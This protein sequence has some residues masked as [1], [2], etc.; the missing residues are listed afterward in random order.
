[1]KIIVFSSLAY[2]LV[3]FRGRLLRAMVA[4]GHDV[5][6]CAPDDNSDVRA[7]LSD[8]G[9]E[10][11][12][13]PMARTGLNPLEDIKTLRKMVAL[14]RDERPD[15]V[16]AYT[17][18][19][20]IYGGVAAR[21]V[22]GIR[23]YAMCSGLGHVYSGGGLRIGILRR[24]VSGLYR[25][26][27]SK[28]DGVFVFNRDDAQEMR[29]HRIVSPHQIVTRVNGSGIDVARFAW[30]P[31]SSGPPVFLM[32]AR[33][34]RD[35]GPADFAKA[36][37]MVKAVNKDAKFRLLGPFDANPNSVTQKELD[38]WQEES[39]IEYL[40]STTDVRP[41]LTRCT[42]FVLPTF[43]R[44]GLPRTILEAMATGRAIITTDTPG[45]RE[46]VIE[47]ENG[48]LVKPRDPEGL[49]RA[50]IQIASVEGRA[51]DFG[52]VS[53]KI[54][55]DRFAVEKVNA[56]LLSLM[57]LD[58]QGGA[59]DPC[60]APGPHELGMPAAPLRRGIDVCAAL[61]ALI[62]LTPA[63]AVSALAV[64]IRMGGPVLFRQKRAGLGKRPFVLVKFRTMTDERDAAGALLPDARRTTAIG[65][66]L[67]RFRIDE[68]PQFWNV[69]RGDMSLFGPRPMLPETI[70]EFGV[71]GVTR[72]S[73]RPG[74][75]GWAQIHGG[76]LLTQQDKLA[77]DNWYVN[78]RS[79][80]TDLKIL[81][82]TASVIVFDDEIDKTAIRRAN[83]RF[84]SRS[85]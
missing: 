3:N 80:H 61:A 84:D 6:A 79:I 45:C 25:M 9:V 73:I 77:L 58:R 27:V 41:H 69:L 26:A 71:Q 29:R 34:M 50:M 7:Q 8:I 55:E 68:F 22:G 43:Y 10:F 35:K 31:V 1:M 15:V 51:Q 23:Y 75:T 28:A 2:S 24:V 66:F 11:R 19:P 83:A 76:P 62:I 44:E 36:S 57:R 52:N 14:L 4:A 39:G 78:N 42:T 70:D 16:M 65:R 21:I 33:L 32:I 63:L 67:R 30:E 53:R 17:Q 81:L 5:I 13:V 72:S 48:Y 64:R 85:G 47:G 74:L 54:A 82:K 37:A 59:V 38:Q 40:G 20:I 60:D 18:K 49:A 46:T 56:H 12:T